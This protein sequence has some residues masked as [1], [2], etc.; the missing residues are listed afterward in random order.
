MK[1]VSEAVEE[2]ACGAG[3]QAQRGSWPTGDKDGA[4][5][6]GG[7]RTDG[8]TDGQ[9]GRRAENQMDA[10]PAQPPHEEPTAE[11]GPARGPGRRAC[12]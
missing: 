2:A 9:E 8:R 12:F 7:R 1:S 11:G 5:T 4:V 3:K 6:V 10:G